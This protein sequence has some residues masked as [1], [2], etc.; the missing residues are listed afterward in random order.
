MWILEFFGWNLKMQKFFGWFLH[1]IKEWS[2]LG[3]ISSTLCV[4]WRYIVY[5]PENQG[6]IPTQFFP[7]RTNVKKQNSKD[8]ALQI[9]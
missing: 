3:N 6:Q 5:E 9:E 2:F 8:P 4:S 7:M 1:R